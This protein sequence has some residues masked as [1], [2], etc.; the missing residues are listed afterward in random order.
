MLGEKKLLELLAQTAT[1]TDDPHGGKHFL[2]ARLADYSGH[3]PLADDQT[4]ILIR[5]NP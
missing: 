3:A 2:L 1:Q 4:L 5:H